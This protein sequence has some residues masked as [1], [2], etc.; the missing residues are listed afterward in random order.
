MPFC[1]VEIYSSPTTT[2]QVWPGILKGWKSKWTWSW[3]TCGS[4]K[5]LPPADWQLAHARKITLKARYDVALKW[6]SRLHVIYAEPVWRGG[7]EHFRTR[8]C[9]SHLG[10]A[11]LTSPRRSERPAESRGWPV[12]RHTQRSW[13]PHLLPLGEE[14]EKAQA[15]IYSIWKCIYVFIRYFTEVN[16]FLIFSHLFRSVLTN[17]QHLNGVQTNK[18]LYKPIILTEEI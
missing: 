6:F 14:Q 7:T 8:W 10:S 2:C 1:G 15:H 11:A 9:C 18:T 17:Y 12:R 16:N 3:L 4:V 5:A 13:P